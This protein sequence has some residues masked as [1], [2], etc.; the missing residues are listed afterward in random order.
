LLW[1]RDIMDALAQYLDFPQP[2]LEPFSAPRDPL[3]LSEDDIESAARETRRYWGLRDG[4]IP[5]VVWLLEANGIVVTCGQF[6]E[7]TMDS[8][9]LCEQSRAHP[10]V[11]IN[12][13][14]GSAVRCRFDAAH[15]LGHLLLHTGVA[16]SYWNGDIRSR[17]WQADRF[18]S[19]F[20]LPAEAFS[21]DV[22]FASLDGLRSLK[23]KWLV[24]IA[25]MLM[26]CESL[27]I[28][29]ESDAER[30]WRNLSRRKWR[31]VEPLDDS[32]VIEEPR[33]LPRA[34][35]VLSEHYP[36]GPQEVL[37]AVQ[38][39]IPDICSLAMIDADMFLKAGADQLIEFRP[40]SP[41]LA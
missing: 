23:P 3:Q 35:E 25:A 1:L 17:E 36:S 29:R 34:F 21:E 19:A 14:K 26:R 40:K 33:V 38:L 2:K 13:D 4:P 7:A 6:S 30:L 24:S 37:Q 32:L 10:L 11:F 22:S 9:S 16:E 31:T 28:I 8:F 12:T 18:A 41:K 39:S 5:N 15:E 27:G 20:L